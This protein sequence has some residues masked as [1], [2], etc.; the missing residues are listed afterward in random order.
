MLLNKK[1]MIQ[2][3][4]AAAETYDN[5]AVLH[6]E[7]A[8]RLLQR[9]DLIRLQPKS[10][11]DLG[12]GKGYCLPLLKQ[13]YV[14]SHIVALDIAEPIIAK[15]TPN[16]ELSEALNKTKRLDIAHMPVT[17]SGQDDTFVGVLDCRAVHRA[18]S[19]EVLSRQRKADSIHRAAV[20]RKDAEATA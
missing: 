11:I 16:I 20:S 18:L 3:F 8:D 1:L 2:S 14:N 17:V 9:L 7:V 15:V 10:I 4:N 19:A 6:R 13:R 5:A 12:A